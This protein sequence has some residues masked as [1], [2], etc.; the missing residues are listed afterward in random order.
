[1]PDPIDPTAWPH[2]DWADS[3]D[4]VA[5]A[6]DLVSGRRFRVWY[7]REEGVR[8]PGRLGRGRPRPLIVE[9]VE[10]GLPIAHLRAWEE[11]V[12]WHDSELISAGWTVL[13]TL[14]D[15]EAAADDAPPRPEPRSAI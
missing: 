7:D 5:G 4:P 6:V 11:V 10:N 14:A 3:L 1:M 15:E 13:Q 9:D 12:A 8:R 2:P